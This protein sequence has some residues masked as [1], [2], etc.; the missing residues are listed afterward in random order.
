MYTAL[1]L[2]PDSV[3]INN[4]RNGF[5]RRWLDDDGRKLADHVVQQVAGGAGANFLEADFGLKKLSF[6]ESAKDLRGLLLSGIDITFPRGENLS[7]MNLNYW[8][9]R[10]STLRHAAFRSITGNFA[11]YSGVSFDSCTFI[12]VSLYGTEFE[13]CVFESCNFLER[14][15]FSNCS[16]KNTMF[17]NCFFE[18][19]TFVDC[20]FDELT[21]VNEPVKQSRPVSVAGYEA[22]AFK[23][24]YLAAIYRG[25][26]EAY[27]A[28]R[29]SHLQR[30]YIYAEKH[31]LTRYNTPP[32]GRRIARRFLEVTTGYGIKPTRVLLTA[33]ALFAVSASIFTLEFGIAGFMLSAGSFFTFGANTDLLK[34]A[35]FGLQALYVLFAFLGVTATSTFI[36]VLTNYWAALR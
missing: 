18:T 2:L 3:A 6:L 22:I 17:K 31:A 11:T 33:L 10:D 14:N 8:D 35:G 36:V 12:G 15:T 7:E 27:E 13:D 25:I 19:D 32:G 9:C 16:F 1:N 21:R 5:R 20:R 29:I 30:G 23:P 4:R 26:R 28:G 34:S 24:A